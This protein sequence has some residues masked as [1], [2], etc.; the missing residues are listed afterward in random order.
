MK[1]YGSIYMLI[2][3]SLLCFLL[4][5]CMSAKLSGTGVN[6]QDSTHMVSVQANSFN[7]EF[8]TN[9]IK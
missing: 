2:K 4:N 6:V 9:E 1:I 5:G 8:S 3:I 7:A